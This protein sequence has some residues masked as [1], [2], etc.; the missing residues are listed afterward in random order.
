MLLPLLLLLLIFIYTLHAYYEHPDV[1][2]VI[3]QISGALYCSFLLTFLISSERRYSSTAK[4]RGVAYLLGFILLG[5]ILAS[6]G[7]FVVNVFFYTPPDDAIKPGKEASVGHIE[8]RPFIK[9]GMLVRP[10][11]TPSLSITSEYP[12]LCGVCALFPVYAAFAQSV[13]AGLDKKSVSEIVDCSD[14]SI[15]LPLLA[16]CAD[17]LFGTTPSQKQRDY[18]A[19]KGLTLMETPIGREA[20][21]FLVHRDNPVRSLTQAQIRSI[22]SGRI[23]NWKEL[24]GPDEAILAFQR[25]NAFSF[26]KDEYDSQRIMQRIME[27]ETLIHPLREHRSNEVAAYRNRKNAIGYSLRWYATTLFSSSDIRL[28]AIDGVDPTPE[29]IRNGTY[30]FIV[31]ILAVAARP[32]SSQSKSLLEWITS[33]EGQD[34]LERAGYVPLR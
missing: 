7:P 24:G 33:P 32:L 5:F 31:P 16:D 26:D 25:P 2:L 27:G 17:I 22:Y 3:F 29:N 9:S 11:S 28:L 34:L 15:Y 21:V 23:S 30:P 20:F 8:L 18:V 6:F 14:S 19:A 1:V 13:Y 4:A 12:R 10:S